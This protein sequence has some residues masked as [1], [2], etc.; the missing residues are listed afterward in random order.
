MT[1][2]KHKFLSLNETKYGSVTFGNNALRRIKGK[3][4][5]NLNN[6]KGKSNDMLFFDGLKHNL[7]SVR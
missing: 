2:N 6:G 1:G 5:V 3:G 7:M 4:L